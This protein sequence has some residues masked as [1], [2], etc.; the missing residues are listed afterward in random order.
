MKV[1]ADFKL[2]P[3][4]CHMGYISTDLSRNNS[5]KKLLMHFMH[6]SVFPGLV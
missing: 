5:K 4:I 1:I 2:P 3:F 6:F